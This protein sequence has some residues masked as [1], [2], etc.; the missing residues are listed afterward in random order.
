[1]DKKDCIWTINPTTTVYKNR[2]LTMDQLTRLIENYPSLPVK[3]CLRGEV[4]E[5]YMDPY[6]ESEFEYKLKDLDF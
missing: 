1:M 4:R 6:S 3:K 5:Y 2:L